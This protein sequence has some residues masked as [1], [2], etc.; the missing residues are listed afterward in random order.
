MLDTNP[1]AVA[2]EMLAQSQDERYHLAAV[3]LFQLHALKAP[4]ARQQTVITL[5]QMGARI[6][7]GVRDDLLKLMGVVDH[8]GADLATVLDWYRTTHDTSLMWQARPVF[9]WL[10]LLGRL[11]QALRDPAAPP[12]SISARAILLSA[13]IDAHADRGENPNEEWNEA[14]RSLAGWCG[15]PNLV[16]LLYADTGLPNYRERMR[17]LLTGECSTGLCEVVERGALLLLFRRRAAYLRQSYDL[18]ELAMPTNI[19]EMLL[20]A[21]GA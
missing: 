15:C 12:L 21:I 3:A 11:A 20:A 19:R 14:V 1:D 10:D 4:D 7:V 8:R 17:S 9:E 2:R 16:F 18:D 13:V 6:P 5:C